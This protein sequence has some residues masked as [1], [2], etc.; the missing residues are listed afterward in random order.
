MLTLFRRVQF[1]GYPNSSRETYVDL[2]FSHGQQITEYLQQRT[3]HYAQSYPWA[4]GGLA[5]QLDKYSK[6]HHIA[7]QDETN[8][9]LLQSLKLKH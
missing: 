1:D 9:A 6:D 5:S 7:S 3:C 8:D 2:F 4:F